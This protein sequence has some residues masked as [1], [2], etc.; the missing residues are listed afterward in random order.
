MVNRIIMSQTIKNGG[1]FQQS[2]RDMCGLLWHH[3]KSTEAHCCDPF[4]VGQKSRPLLRG[5]L[6]KRINRQISCSNRTLLRNPWCSNSAPV[7]YCGELQIPKVWVK[8]QSFRKQITLKNLKKMLEMSNVC[9]ASCFMLF[10]LFK[11]L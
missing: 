11:L 4:Q 10:M 3:N 1:C 5:K 8:A 6:C 9:L 7:M 2:W